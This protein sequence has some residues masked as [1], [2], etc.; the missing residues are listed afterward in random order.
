MDVQFEEM[1]DLEFK[2]QKLPRTTQRYFQAYDQKWKELIE[3]TSNNS[4]RTLMA[5]F[6]VS[7]HISRWHVW[8]RYSA[9]YEKIRDDVDISNYAQLTQFSCYKPVKATIFTK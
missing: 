5:N 3:A 9:D 7:G 2:G 4:E 8:P 6:K 1:K